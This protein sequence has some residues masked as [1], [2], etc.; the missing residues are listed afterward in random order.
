M[1]S[2]TKIDR[3]DLVRADLARGLERA[4]KGGDQW[5]EGVLQLASAL[6][7]GSELMPPDMTFSTWLQKQGLDVLAAKDRAALIEM[8]ADLEEMRAMLATTTHSSIT[9]I[10]ATLKP[11]AMKPPTRKKYQRNPRSRAMLLR[12]LKLGGEKNMRKIKGTSLDNATEMDELVV[13]NRG[14][15]EG[16]VTPLVKKLIDDAHAGKEIS[17]VATSIAMGGRRAGVTTLI[18]AWKKRMVSTW[19]QASDEERIKFMTFLGLKFEL[20]KRVSLLDHLMEHVSTTA[21]GKP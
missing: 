5:Q 2:I 16:E 19:E 10:L 13:L 14:A 6:R 1:S 21:E 3:L 17:A 20:A 18:A 11:T 12:S 7:R 4:T 9:S 15:P 8:A